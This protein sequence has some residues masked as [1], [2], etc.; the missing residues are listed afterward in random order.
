MTDFRSCRNCK[1]HRQLSGNAH[2]ACL[3]PFVENFG[4]AQIFLFLTIGSQDKTINPLE[5][6]ANEK[7]LMNGWF[8][9]P[10]DF[11]PVWLENCNGFEEATNETD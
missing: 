6:R 7:G 11:D 5:I 4:M 8:N 10:F 9:W 1:Y 3:H 2:L